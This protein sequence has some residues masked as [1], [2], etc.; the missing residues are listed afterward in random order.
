MADGSIERVDEALDGWGRL[1]V[2]SGSMHNLADWHK[3][4]VTEI[5][6]RRRRKLMKV[7]TAGKACVVENDE[8]P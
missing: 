2:I 6:T 3:D 7:S 8:Q 1:S 4:G 5:P